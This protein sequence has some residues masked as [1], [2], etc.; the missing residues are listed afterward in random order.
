MSNKRLTAE[1]VRA[2]ASQHGK[3]GSRVIANMV[4][5]ADFVQAINTKVGQELLKDIMILLDDK[6]DMIINEKAEAE[7]RAEFRVLKKLT[8][9]WTKRINIYTDAVEKIKSGGK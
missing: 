8:I 2:Y 3:P 7:D 5:N 9:A 6:L 4:K 1:E